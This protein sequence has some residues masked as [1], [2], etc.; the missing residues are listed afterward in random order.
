MEQFNIIKA[1]SLKLVNK[2]NAVL[3]K[4][5]ARFFLDHDKMILNF[6]F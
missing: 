5:P 2:L 4:I 3:T 1:I 6:I